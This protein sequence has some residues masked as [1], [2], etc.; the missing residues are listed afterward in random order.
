M[1]VGAIVTFLVLDT[2]KFVPSAS[3]YCL[4]TLLIRTINM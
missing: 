2:I 3:K 4:I 1:V